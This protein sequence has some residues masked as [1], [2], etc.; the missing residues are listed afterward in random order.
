MKN[1]YKMKYRNK[2]VNIYISYI[3]ISVY[4]CLLDQQFFAGKKKPIDR[5]SRIFNSKT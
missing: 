4:K 2:N 1:Y 3:P 5:I